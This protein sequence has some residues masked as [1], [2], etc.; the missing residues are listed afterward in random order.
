MMNPVVADNV[1]AVHIFCPW[2]VAREQHADATNMTNFVIDDS[3]VL[4]VQ[5]QPDCCAA[6]G[7]ETAGLHSTIFRAAK[8]E[9]SRGPIKYFPV[10]LQTPAIAAVPLEPFGMLEGQ[11]AKNH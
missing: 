9:R 3:V 4:T 8:S 5:I 1:F 7:S 11:P 6:A 10:M 2:T